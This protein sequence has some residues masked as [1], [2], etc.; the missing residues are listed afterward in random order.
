MALLPD[1][2]RIRTVLTLL[3]GLTASHLASI[4]LYSMTGMGMMGMGTG[5][6]SSGSTASTLVMI[7]AIVVFSWWASGWITEPL[8]DFARA[9]EQ[10]GMD[11]NAPPLD[12]NGPEEVRAAARAFNQMQIRIRTFVEDRLRML[13]AISHDMRGP[14]TRLRLR[15][16]Q[17]EMD[18]NAEGKMLADLDE[19]A[20]MV[21]SSLAF[22]RDEA[23]DEASHPVDLAALL[24]TLCDDAVDAGHNAEFTWEGRLVYQ[25]RPL[26]MKRL[27]ANLI[28]NAL[29]YGGDATVSASN[30]PEGL[31]VFI[32]DHGPG[33]PERERENVF[34]P[35]FRLEKSRNKRTG[36]I[37]LGLATARSIARAH[38]G[39]VVLEN[40]PEG[41]L[42]AIVILPRRS[43]GGA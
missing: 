2:I 1:S 23:T 33:I 42:R 7:V 39:D 13:A 14:I 20:Q 16:E 25:G 22:A 10:L 31:R 8:S 28:D 43:S 9:S 38:G 36:G 37:G 19:M 18:P 29:R 17:I 32:D 24:N 26:A 5:A 30:D 41:G 21:D 15:I 35:F 12:E 3:V 4:A 11:V 27:F 40:R 6:W 34:R